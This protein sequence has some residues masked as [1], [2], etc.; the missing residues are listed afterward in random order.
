MYI[1]NYTVKKECS[2]TRAVFPCWRV[3]DASERLLQ[4]SFLQISCAKA[5]PF[6]ILPVI[7]AFWL[8]TDLQF[9]H[10][11]LF[12]KTCY[13]RKFGPAGYGFGVGAGVL[14]TDKENEVSDTKRNSVTAIPGGE[15]GGIVGKGKR[16]RERKKKRGRERESESERASEHTDRRKTHA[17]SH[18]RVHAHTKEKNSKNIRT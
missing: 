2:C 14:S 12:C 15:S 10:T 11:Q 4:K 7:A 16:E 9:S 18:T 3:A 17:R 13:G 1:Q 8:D 5:I 6:S